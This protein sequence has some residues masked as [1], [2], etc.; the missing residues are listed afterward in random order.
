MKHLGVVK[1]L[2]NFIVLMAGQTGILVSIEM[3]KLWY[4]PPGF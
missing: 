3:A 2:E 4:N 1:N